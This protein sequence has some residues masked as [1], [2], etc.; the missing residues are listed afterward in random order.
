[1][2]RR[3]RDVKKNGRRRLVFDNSSGQTHPVGQTRANPFGL[4]DIYG[5]AC[6]LAQRN[7]TATMDVWQPQ[8]GMA[9]S[10]PAP[11]IRT[12]CGGCCRS[13]VQIN[14]LTWFNE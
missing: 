4:H 12:A 14:N 7:K 13:L 2:P 10:N 3:R 5:N 11:Q 8:R 1:M 9:Y 6:E